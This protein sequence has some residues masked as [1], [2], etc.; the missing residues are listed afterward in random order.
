MNNEQRRFEAERRLKA[1]RVVTSMSRGAVLHLSFT[2]TGGT[3]SLSDGT[4][5]PAEIAAEVLA[6]LCV[7]PLDHG[8]FPRATAQSWHYQEPRSS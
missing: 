6:H 1:A 4:R 8:L 5:V 2:R 7:V 3:Y